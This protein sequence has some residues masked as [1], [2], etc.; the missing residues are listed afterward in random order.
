MGLLPLGTGDWLAFET[1]G[2]VSVFAHHFTC[3]HR[4]NWSVLGTGN[5]LILNIDSMYSSN[6]TVYLEQTTTRCTPTNAA[7]LRIPTDWSVLYPRPHVCVFP[8]G[9]SAQW[10]SCG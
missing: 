9:S 7:N 8:R 5:Y 3:G 2:I 6:N 1:R 4:S 10:D